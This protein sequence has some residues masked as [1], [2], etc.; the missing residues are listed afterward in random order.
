MLTE[1]ENLKSFLRKNWVLILAVFLIFF[2][3]RVLSL[4]WDLTSYDVRYWRPRLWNFWE[5]LESGELAKTYQR[6]HPGVTV[7]WLSGAAERVFDIFGEKVTGHSLRFLPEWYP[8]RHFAAKFPLVFVISGLGAYCY[9]VLKKVTNSFY[10]FI[11]S[12]LLSFEPFFLG[13]SRYL[14]VSVLTSMFM[15]S[16]FLTLYL[17]VFEKKRRQSVLSS[18]FLGFAVLTKVNGAMVAFPNAVLLFCSCF[19]SFEEIKNF[20]KWK[21]FLTRSLVYTGISVFVFFAFWPAMWVRPV[22]VIEDIISGGLRGTAF[23]SAGAA[24]LSPSRYFYYFEAFFLRSLPT[25]VF[26][27]ISAVPLV[28]IEKSKKMKKFLLASVPLFFFT[29]LFLSIPTKTKDR[30]LIIMYPAFFVYVSFALYR[31]VKMVPKRA[32]IIILILLGSY[33]GLTI[34]RYHP[35]YSFYWNDAIGGAQGIKDFGLP[36]ILRGEYFAPAALYL[37][38]YDSDV[39]NKNVVVVDKSQAD[40]FRWYFYGKTFTGPLEMPN[41]YHAHYFVTTPKYLDQIP[42]VCRFVK[43]FGVR[44]PNPYEEVLIF[45]CERHIDN[46]YD[47]LDN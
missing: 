45:D 21:S 19:G 23:E 8:H 1:F 15:F 42:E 10:A 40:S 27:F 4:G 11:F 28:F 7:M 31:I 37:N 29:W 17:Y 43:S 44:A 38:R 24:M 2:V 16:S 13:V 14:H 36:T 33:Y 39:R 41:G 25:T 3:P 35:Q 20:T 12:I 6:Y 30:Y 34:Y 32:A 47:Q 9:F 26:L 22:K 5:A 46:T 18:V